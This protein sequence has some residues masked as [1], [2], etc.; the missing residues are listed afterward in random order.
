MQLIYVGSESVQGKKKGTGEPYGPFYQ[1]HYVTPNESVNTANRQVSAN[2]FQPQTLSVSKEVFDQCNTLKP[3]TKVSVDLTPD[4][5][6]FNRTIVTSVS[7]S[8]GA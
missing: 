2:G 3:L 7:A 1:F 6:N 4:P 8:A 5:K